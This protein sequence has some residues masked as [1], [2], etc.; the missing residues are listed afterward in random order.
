MM[1]GLGAAVVLGAVL[2]L[3]ARTPAVADERWEGL[4]TR[5]QT[6]AYHACLFEAWIQDY[7]YWHSALYS[8]CVLA[9]GAGRYPLDRHYYSAEDYCWYGAHGSAPP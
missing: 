5:A 7:C 4:L 8:Q 1:R 2:F 9:N 6:R 3:S